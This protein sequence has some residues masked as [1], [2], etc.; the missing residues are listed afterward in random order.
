M[1]WLILISVVLIITS[2]IIFIKL[3][4]IPNPVFLPFIPLTIA[5]VYILFLIWSPIYMEWSFFGKNYKVAQINDDGSGSKS[6]FGVICYKNCLNYQIEY[7]LK[8]QFRFDKAGIKINLNF[9]LSVFCEDLFL[10]FL[11]KRALKEESS[12]VISHYQTQD[13][14]NSFLSENLAISGYNLS[15][16]LK[17]KN[18]E[19]RKREFLKLL[20]PEI[21]EKLENAGLRIVDLDLA[22]EN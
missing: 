21:E 3:L 10:D 6:G 9:F 8:Q 15:R 17:I 5:V 11:V 7:D 13:A 19:R 1:G 22:K 16:L 18:K 14:V 2:F 20:R 4:D 12:L